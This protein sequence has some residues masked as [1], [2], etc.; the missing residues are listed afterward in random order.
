MV[1]SFPACAGK[2]LTVMLRVATT[3]DV[4]LVSISAQKPNAEGANTET[5]KHK[6]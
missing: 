3:I 5:A 1:V 6:S 2:I 4:N